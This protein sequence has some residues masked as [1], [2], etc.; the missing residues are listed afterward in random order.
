MTT[1][2]V[3]DISGENKLS[4]IYCEEE[5]ENDH[6]PSQAK[7]IEET[8]LEEIT[9][10]IS[11]HALDGICTCQTLKINGY[12]KKRKVTVLIDYGISHNYIQCKLA[13]ALHF[14][15][16]PTPEFQVMIEN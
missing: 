10:T 2:I 8:T 11:C 1:S 14:F 5:E 6:E 4:Y 12:I 3:R 15:I 9:H 13:K 16:Y 7:D